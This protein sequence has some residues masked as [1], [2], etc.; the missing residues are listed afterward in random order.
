MV[1]CVKV[2]MKSRIAL[3]GGGSG[4]VG[5]AVV[6]RL[7]QRDWRVIATYRNRPGPADPGVTWVRFDGVG[8]SD[9]AAVRDAVRQATDGL[10]AFF[11]CIGAPS[12]KHTVADTPLAEFRDLH[13]VNVLSFVA[14]WSAIRDRARMGRAGVVAVGSE[15]AATLR[16][17]SGPY[18][19]TKAALHAL[20][21]TLA[22]E[23]A[24]FG[25]RANVLAPSR[26]DS[27]MARAVRRAAPPNAAAAVPLPWGRPLSPAEVAAVIVELGTGAEWS[28]LS[29]EVLPLRA[30]LH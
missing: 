13:A 24:E 23:E 5:G 6:G 25:V 29:G 16:P 2:T 7:R 4:T 12:S 19:A 3:V 1:G 21:T 9:I 18:S 17:H 28:Y 22:R 27:P 11:F 26:I 15:A 8:E 10:H 20:V 30:N 14:L